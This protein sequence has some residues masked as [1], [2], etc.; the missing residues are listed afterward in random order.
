MAAWVRTGRKLA[1]RMRRWLELLGWKVV[2]FPLFLALSTKPGR[3]LVDRVFF[4][5]PLSSQ[6][7]S[8]G[9]PPGFQTVVVWQC[10]AD[11]LRAAFGSDRELSATVRALPAKTDVDYVY[12]AHTTFPDVVSEAI[13]FRKVLPRGGVL[14]V[15]SGTSVMAEDA[16]RKEFR[17][18][19]GLRENR[20]LLLWLLHNLRYRFAAI[21][22]DFSVLRNVPVFLA[23]VR[24][25]F[26]YRPSGFR[27]QRS[28][29]GPRDRRF[30]DVR[31]ADIERLLLRRAALVMHFYEEEA[32]RHLERVLDT[33]PVNQLAI[34]PGVHEQL[35]RSLS[36][37]DY[38]PDS[39]IHVVW[40]GGYVRPG[41]GATPWANFTSDWKQ[42][43][44]SGI[45]VHAYFSHTRA[46]D[47]ELKPM[48]DFF[49]RDPYFHIHS[50]VPF[51]EL[52]QEI[53][54]Y[55]FL[56]AY[57]AG[58]QTDFHRP[59]R[60]WLSS[61]D[62]L[63]LGAGVPVIVNEFYPRLFDIVKRYGV[64]LAVPSSQADRLPEPI[65]AADRVALRERCRQ[66]QKLFAFPEHRVQAALEAVMLEPGRDAGE[67]GQEPVP[68][69]GSAGRF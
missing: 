65:R 2:T 36:E 16:C 53:Q 51:L 33:G 30:P 38:Y 55:D 25:K 28:P 24:S 46:D 12:L 21:R 63:G 31:G 32:V 35:V 64:G 60:G 17:Q 18:V 10:L 6:L 43:T 7:A 8:L 54:S 15:L 19:I 29:D 44:G 62:C 22:V 34:W 37:V 50:A 59:F 41:R 23:G 13:T 9:L 66:H 40:F 20:Y 49:N 58:E 11:R 3:W 67:S 39:E 61:H 69:G 48:R 42:L 4:G 5:M 52:Y 56:W 1:A 45:H 57:Y 27:S 14:V 26:L 47:E 68:R